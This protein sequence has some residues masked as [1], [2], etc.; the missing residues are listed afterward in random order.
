VWLGWRSA[1]AKTN[2]QK[3]RWIFGA[4]AVLLD[5]IAEGRSATSMG[6][7]Q[8]FAGHEPII[9]KL[10]E[11]I[12]A[13]THLSGDHSVT[14][15]FADTY[16]AALFRSI[17]SDRCVKVEWRGIASLWAIS[18]AAGILAP[19]MFNTRRRGAD[20]VNLQEGSLEAL[21]YLLIGYAKDLCI[22]QPWRW[23][24]YFPYPDPNQSSEHAKYG[25]VFFVRSL[26]WIL[27]H[28][29]A[30]V[31]LGHQDTVWNSGQSRAEERDA[32]RNASQALKGNLVV[33]SGRPAG[34]QPS[35]IELELERRAIAAGIGLMWVAV[36][37][38]TGDQPSEMYPPIADR[39]YRNLDEF[40]LAIDSMA[41]EVISDLIK[42][43]VDPEANWPTRPGEEATAQAALDEA[44]RRLDVYLRTRPR[45]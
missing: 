34:A 11:R 31:A 9:R 4:P 6:L 39:L 19:A 12:A 7:D 1:G 45:T 37:E 2:V 26:E 18:Q 25:E 44:C 13:E 40:S 27:R 41:A 28:E 32:D 10:F 43:W 8:L 15:E 23:N 38:D 35:A 17:P 42:G 3:S 36:N 22:R 29:L 33:D 5:V 21:G 14:L 20:R 30:H 16:N 24:T